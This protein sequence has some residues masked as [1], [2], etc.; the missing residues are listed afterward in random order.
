M[1]EIIEITKNEIGTEEINSVNAREIHEYLEV[2]TRFNDWINRAIKKYD[3]KE[4]VDYSKMSIPQKGNPKP[5]QDYIV[6][7]DMAKELS[8]LENNA[9]GKETRKYFIQAEKKLKEVGTA[10]NDLILQFMSN[11]QQT[12]TVIVKLLEKLV[13]N[14]EQQIKTINKE[15]MKKI[16]A[17][18]YIIASLAAE[19]FEEVMKLQIKTTKKWEDRVANKDIKDKVEVA[20]S[21]MNFMNESMDLDF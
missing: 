3:F 5:I 10:N 2:K 15:Q 19:D 17:N 18:T 12:N 6:T 7:V 4:N 11:Q 8:M 9:K 20:K 21:F 1:K 16:R 13:D 14:Q